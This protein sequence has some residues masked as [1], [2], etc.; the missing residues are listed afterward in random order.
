MHAMMV[1]GPPPC[2]LELAVFMDSRTVSNNPGLP[3]MAHLRSLSNPKAIHALT[4]RGGEFVV[5]T[6]SGL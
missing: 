2:E 4:L 6:A 3:L 1:D 5:G